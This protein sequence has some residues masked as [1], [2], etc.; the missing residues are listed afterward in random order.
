MR[1]YWHDICYYFSAEGCQWILGSHK[2]GELPWNSSHD[3][4]DRS[5]TISPD[6]VQAEIYCGFITTCMK[7]I[8]RDSSLIQQWTL[9]VRGIGLFAV[10]GGNQWVEASAGHVRIKGLKLLA[11][12]CSP[13][14]T[15]TNTSPKVSTK[16]D[17]NRKQEN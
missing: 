4:D 1:Y 5:V 8:P 17:E 15:K 13:L 7:H 11:V 2:S 3:D 12:V 6:D 9:T 14:R 10:K 16:D